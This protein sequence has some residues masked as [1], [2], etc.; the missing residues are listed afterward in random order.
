MSKQKVFQY[1]VIFQDEEKPKFIVPLTTVL[2]KD[3]RSLTLKVAREIPEKY[4][5]ELDK[6]EIV[7]KPF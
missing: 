6:V 5:E 3:E 4:V 7:V 2:A 1:L